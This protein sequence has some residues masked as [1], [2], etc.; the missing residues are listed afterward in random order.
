MDWKNESLTD[1]INH[2]GTNHHEYL[3]KTM[4]ELSK[5]TTTILRVH[6]GSHKELA[7]VHRLFHIIQIDL[8]QLLIKQESNIFPTIKYIDKKPSEKLLKEILHEIDASVPIQ[9]EI[10][11]LLKE[12]REITNNY[13]APEDGCVTYDRTYDT[14]RE[15]ASN[16]L[17]HLDLENN[18]LLPRLKEELK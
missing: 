13:I 7:K 18:I 10:R 1:L 3:K 6:G 11:N 4:P 9:E 12:L 17:E 2:I 14:L 15:F 8:V 5:L 16:I